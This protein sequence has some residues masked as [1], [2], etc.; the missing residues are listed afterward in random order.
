MLG[1]TARMPMHRANSII[2]RI[3]ITDKSKRPDASRAFFPFTCAVS[4]RYV[5][6]SAQGKAM[7]QHGFDELIKRRIGP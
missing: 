4:C 2:S 7:L 5:V 1:A 3:A 6:N